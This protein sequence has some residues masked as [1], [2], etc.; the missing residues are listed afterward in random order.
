MYHS[1]LHGYL[2]MKENIKKTTQP[3]LGGENYTAPECRIIEIDA[4]WLMVGS[5]EPPAEEEEEVDFTF[6]TSTPSIWG[7]GEDHNME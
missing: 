4:A 1:T 6:S 3:P 5:Q 2:S 7:G